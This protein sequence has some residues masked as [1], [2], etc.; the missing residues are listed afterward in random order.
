VRNLLLISFT[1]LQIILLIPASSKSQQL[2]P[3]EFNESSKCPCFQSKIRFDDS[4]LEKIVLHPEEVLANSDSFWANDSSYQLVKLWHQRIS[5]PIPLDQWKGWMQS[6]KNIPVE[7]RKKNTQ[8]IAAKSMMGKEKEFNDKAIP[9]IC[10]F[11]PKDCPDI[12]TTIYFTTAIMASGFQ[13]G[14]SIVI[15]GSNADKD[16]L[17]IHELFHQGFNKCK[18]T[19]HKC[20]IKDSTVNQIFND[21]Q[22]EGIATYVGYKALNEFPKF[23]PDPKRDDY[24]FF[25]DLKTR[26]RL[27]ER[28]NDILKKVPLLVDTKVGQKELQDSLWQV[29]TND[30]A[31]YIVGC[32]MAMI[33]DEKLGRNALVE[34]ISKGPKSFLDSYNSLVEEKY[35]VFDLYK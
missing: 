15:Y 4:S 30:R 25:T 29:G 16:N 26:K 2:T 14:N 31:I 5:F 34:T 9:F 23:D 20:S 35:L 8:L 21:I 19:D 6:F 1:Y 33:I 7:E 24:R 27:F 13:M 10:S 32:Y 11:L 18:P 22:N 17:F 3:K 12:S 28:L